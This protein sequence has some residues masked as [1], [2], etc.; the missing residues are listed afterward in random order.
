M[1]LK[2]SVLQ[3]ALLPNSYVS[4]NATFYTTEGD[5]NYLM[6][7]DNFFEDMTSLYRKQKVLFQRSCEQLKVKLL[8][9]S[10]LDY[11]LND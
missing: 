8:F 6:E 5:A 2:H 1:I 3:E 9:I 11:Y 7:D 4:S 10:D